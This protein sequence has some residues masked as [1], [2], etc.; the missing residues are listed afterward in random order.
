MQKLKTIK[1]V[2]L[3][4]IFGALF[5][6]T[7]APELI[8]NSPKNNNDLRN[9]KYQIVHITD[10]S[11]SLS[12]KN[13]SI[14]DKNNYVITYQQQQQTTSNYS[15]GKII[16][17]RLLEIESKGFDN[18]VNRPVYL[19]PT[20]FKDLCQKSAYFP[21]WKINNG[22]NNGVFRL[23]INDNEKLQRGGDF[24]Y[25]CVYEEG[26][27][28]QITHL[29]KESL[30]N[31]QHLRYVSCQFLIEISDMLIA[32]QAIRFTSVTFFTVFII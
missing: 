23:K 30:L 6:A 11:S 20:K 18:T 17:T 26:A 3:V 7:V 14:D 1:N 31:L 24:Y 4:C 29:G 9:N 27:M 16:E 19:Y 28:N 25:F 32:F 15:E 2:K 5:I 8:N 10:L 22:T 13:S 21:E 12:K